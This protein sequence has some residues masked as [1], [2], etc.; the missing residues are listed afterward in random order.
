MQLFLPQHRQLSLTFLLSASTCSLEALTSW[1]PF[2]M[3]LI[4]IHTRAPSTMVPSKLSS[5]VAS[6]ALSQFFWLRLEL[7]FLGSL[8]FG[9]MVKYRTFLRKQRG[10]QRW[11]LELGMP[12]W[13]NGFRELHTHSHYPANQRK[14]S[15]YVGG[16][17]SCTKGTAQTCNSR[18][19]NWRF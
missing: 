16:L 14:R 13:V 10:L 11:K 4:S 12:Q 1:A 15:R 9:F 19:G 8:V 3:R 7:H 18:L 5:L 6:S 2:T 17:L